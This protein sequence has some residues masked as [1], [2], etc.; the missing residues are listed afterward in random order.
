MDDNRSPEVD[1]WFE[2]YQNPLKPLVQAVREVILDTDPRMTEAVK[3]KAPTFMYKGTWLPSTR[4][5]RSTC[6]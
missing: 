4:S 6:P 1:A 5:P 2:S 3:W